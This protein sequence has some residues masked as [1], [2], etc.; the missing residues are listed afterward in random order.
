[1]VYGKPNCI[2][3]TNIFFCLEVWLNKQMT[4]AFNFKDNQ[5]TIKSEVKI[6]FLK[7]NTEVFRKKYLGKYQIIK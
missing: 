5:R 3:A 4:Y 2:F 6:L 7:L 1:M